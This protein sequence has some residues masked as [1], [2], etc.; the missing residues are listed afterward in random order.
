[1][2]N[3][4]TLREYLKLAMADLQQTRHRLRELETDATEPIAIVGMSCRFA[5]GVRTPEDL[6][7]LLAEGGDAVGGFPAD[8]GWDLESLYDPDPDRPGTS[9]TREGGFLTG[10]GDFDAG[11]FGISPREALAMDPQQRLLLETSWEVLERGGIDPLSLKGTQ[12]GVFIGTNGQDYAG[13][14]VASEEPVGGFVSTGNAASVVSGRISY[15]FGLE[16]PAVTVDTACSASLVALHLAVRSLR[17]RECS[18]AIAGGI[19]IMSTPGAFV[20]FSRQRGLAE[21]GR[22]KAF[23]AAADGTGW[24]E[25]VGMLLLMRLSDAQRLGHEVLA[26]VR[27]SAVNQDGASNGL[28]AP[29]GLS[30]QRVILRALADAHLTTADVDAVEAH[31]TGTTLGDPI[32][33]QALLATYGQDRTEPLK[34]GSVKSNLGHTQ[35]AAGVAGVIKMVLALRHDLLPKTLH[36]DAPTPHVDWTTGAVELLA[37]AQPWPKGDRPRRAGISSF[38]VSGTNAHT[39]IEEAPAPEAASGQPEKPGGPRPTTPWVISGKTAGALQAQAGRLRDVTAAPEDVAFSLLTT[40]ATL[41]H[42]AVVFDSAALS[43]LAEGEPAPGLVKGLA[44][45]TADR[46]AFVFPGQGS[47]WVGMAAELMDTSPV[48]AARMEECAAA[49]RPHVGWDLVEVARGGELER[50]DVVQPVLWAVMVS[51]AEVWRHHGVEPSAVVGHSQGEIAAACVAGALSVEDAAAVVALRSR[52]IL[53]LAGRGGMMSVALP[54]AEL[55][56]DDRLSI[57]AINGPSSVV[58]SGDVDAIEELRASTT[59]RTRVIPVDY[60]S[61]SHHVEEIHDELVRL[62]ADIAPRSSEVPFFSTVTATWLDTTTMDA[63][64]WYRN[65]RNTVRLEEVTRALADQGFGTFVEVSPHPGL[66]SAIQDTADNATVVGTLRRGEGGP[67]RFLTSLAEVHVAGTTVDWKITGTRVALPTYPFQQER[68]W[69][70]PPAGTGDVTA[71]GL[72]APGHPL[73]GAAAPLADSGGFLFT[74]RI[75]LR[76]HPWL[77]DHAV[78]GTVLLPGTAFVEM[79][80]RAGDETG[81]ALVEDL[82]LEAPL[83][84]TGQESVTVQVAVTSGRSITIHSRRGDD[85]PWTRHATGTLAPAASAGEG[86]ETWPVGE[87]V[88]LEGFYEAL[89][90]TGFAYGPAFQGLKRAWRDGADLYAEIALPPAPGFGIHPALLDAALHTGFLRQDG[91]PGL[92]FAWSDVALHATGAT[93]LRV[94]LTPTGPSTVTLTIA[95]PTG[96][97]V[98]TIGALTSRAPEK[99][100]THHDAFYTLTWQPVTPTTEAPDHTVV[101]FAPEPAGDLARAARQATARALEHLQADTE[102]V[103][104]FVTSGAVGVGEEDVHDL[105]NSPIWGLVRSAQSETPG[106]F[107][108]VDTD[109][110]TLIAEAVATGEPQVVVRDG[111]FLAPRLARAP[112]PETAPEFSGTVLV[113]GGT[114]TLGG[115]VARH[116]V[117]AHGVTSLVLVSRTGQAPDLLAELTA[118]GAEAV[119]EAC[120]VTDRA[121]LAEVF[122]RHDIGAVVHTAGALDDGVVASLTPERLDA[123]FAPKVD[124]VVHLHEL[125]DAPLIL[126]SAAAGI[127]GGPGQGNY[128]A[129]NA[130]TDALAR[131]RR[132]HGKPA[133]ALA[134]GFWAERSGLTGHLDD[135][136]VGRMGRSGVA[137][138]SS[139]EGLALFDA[140]VASGEPLIVP[141]RLDL[142]AVRRSGQVPPLLRGLVRAPARRVAESAGAESF[143]DRLAAA[144]DRERYLLDLVAA[145]VATVLGYATPEALD[146]TRAFKELGF[147]SLTAVDLRNRLGAA[148]GLKLPATLVFDYPNPEALAAHLSS[149]FSGTTATVRKRTAVADEP[150]AIVG[151]GCRYPGG[152]R[153]PEDLWRLVSEGVDAVSAFPA[154]RGWDLEALYDPDPDHPGTSYAREGGFLDGVADFDA[155]FFGIS[156]R[157]ALAMDPQQRLLLETSWEAFERAGIRPE[158]VRGS[159]TGVFAGVMYHD[160]ASHLIAG[161][162]DLTELEGYLGNGSAGSVASGRVAYS[163]G[164]EGPAVTVDTACSSSLVALHLAAQALRNGECDL[165]LAGGVTVLATPGLFTEFSKQRGLAADG[166]SKAFAAAADGAGFAEGAGMLLLE[167][168]SDARRHGHPILALIKGSAVNQDGASNGLTAPNGP[169][170]QRVIRQALA[171]AGLTPQDVDAIEAHGTGT[172][173]GDPIEA[174]ALLAT[175]GQDRDEP[176]R[177]GSIKSNIGHTQAAA[178][179]AGVIKMTMA[180]RHGL[181]PKTLH[182]DAPSPHVDWTEGAVELLTEPLP[183]PAGT[184]PRRAAISSF[185]VSGTN[186]HTI[187]EEAPAPKPSRA[188][189][190][191]PRGAGGPELHQAS[192]AS[193]GSAIDPVRPAVWPVSAKSGPAVDA[194]LARL[195]EAVDATTSPHDIAASLIETRSVFDHRAVLVGATTTDL[196]AATP[197]KGNVV[198]GGDRVVM[199]FPGQGSQWIGMAAE[200]MDT[201]PVFAARLNECAAALRP[202]VDWDLIETAR[203]GE[204]DRVDVVQ[205]VLWAV[206]VSLAELWRSYGVEP[207]AVIGHSQGEIAAACVA[208]AL[209]ID[210][211]AAVVALRSKAILALA[212][213]GGMMS[214]AL[215]AAELDL[216]DRLSIAAINGPSSVVVSGDVDAIEE[217]RANTEAR[218]RVIPVDYASHSH[219]VEEIH[220]DLIRLLAEISPQ[221]SHV[222]F[223]STVTGDWL[224]TTTMTGDYWYRNLR[225]T[226]RLEEATRALV[227]QG[228]GS[229]V[230]V[231][232]HPG[233]TFGI[234]ETLDAMESSAAVA[235]TLRRGEGGLDRFLASVAEAH[236]KGARVDWK[237]TGNRV[238]LPTYAF[239]GQRFWPA[240]AEPAPATAGDTA[241]WLAVDDGSL[242]LGVSQEALDEVLPAL[243]AW[244]R[245]RDELAVLDG[246]RYTITWKPVQ[247]SGAPTGRWQVPE[248]LPLDLPTEGDLEGVILHNPSLEELLAAVK[249]PEAKTWVVTS[250]AVSTGKADRVDHPERAQL[251]GLGGVAALELPESWGGLIDVPEELDDRAAAR[252]VAVLAGDEDQVAIRAGGVFARRLVHAPKPASTGSWTPRGTVLITGGTGALGAHAARWL[253]RN[254]AEHLILVSRRG[255]D[256]PGAAEL[257]EELSATVVACDLSDRRAVEQL[258]AE[259][260][261]DAVVHTAGV[262]QRTSL[263]DTTPEEL[264][265]VVAAK[266]DGAR[267]LHELLPNLDAFILYSSNSGVWGGGGQG[268]YAAANA[269]LDA[270]AHHRR[271]SGAKATSVAWGAWAGDG[272]ASGDAGDHLRRRGL[273]PMDPALAIAALQQVMDADDT[274]MAVADVD[275]D[276]FV[277]GYVAERARPLIADLTEARRILDEETGPAE[278][279]SGL[280]RRLAALT[281]TERRRALLTLVREQAAG[282]L[283]HA[284]ATTVDARRAFREIGFD[285]LTAV[286]LRDRLKT[287]TGLRLPASLVFDHPNPAALAD[288]LER[289]LVGV[290]A[291]T[292]QAQAASTSDEPI[293]IVAMACRYPG[294]VRTPEDLWKLL[295]DGTDAI[296]AFPADRGWNVDALYDADPD[297]SGTTYTKKGGFLHDAGGF[298]PGFFGISPREALAMDPQQR[299]LLEASWEVVERAGIDP[300]TLRGTPAGVFVG[301]STQG[302]GTGLE[303]A[304]EGA[305][306]YFLTGSATAVVSGR[307][308]YTLGLEG[309]AIT[310]D[311]ACSSSLVALHLAVQSL[312]NGEC[313]LALAGG[314]T[315][316]ATPGAFIEFS[317]QRGLAADGRCKAFSADADGTGWGEGVGLLLLERLS[318]AKANGHRVLAVVRGS[319]VNQDG[320]S[321]GLSAPNGPSQQRVIRQALAN[322]GLT[323]KDV[324]VVEAHGTG[325]RLGDPIEAQALL[326]TYGQDRDTPLYLGSV[327]S[328]IGHTQSASG[329]AGVIKMVLSLDHDVIPRTLHAAEPTP[330]VDWTAGSVELLADPT[331]WPS[332]DRPRRAAVSSFGVSGT[333]AHVVIEQAPAAVAR[334]EDPAAF[335]PWLLS[336]RTA[337]ALKA[338]VVRLREHIGATTPLTGLAHTLATTRTVF[339]HRAAITGSTRDDLLTGLDAILAGHHPLQGVV[340]SDPATVFLFTGQGSQRAGMGSGLYSRYPVFADAFDAV[341]AR[342]D[343][344]R[345]LHDVI[346]TGEGLD[347]TAYAQPAIF[348]LEVALFRL[349]ESWGVTP[350]AVAGHS[351]GELA[352]A[353]C[354]GILSL[355]DACALVT[356]RAS[357]MAALPSGGAMVALQVPPGE[358]SPDV[359]IA[360]INGPTSVVISGPEDAV[361][362]EA[363]RFPTSKRL[364]VSHA[365]H[366][367]L[368]DPMLD[369]FRRAIAGLTFNEP[370]IPFEGGRDADYWVRHVRD[371]VRFHDTLTRHAGAVFVEIGP[372]AALT[373]MADAPVIPTLTRSVPETEALITALAT[374]HVRGVAVDWAQVIPS[375]ADVDAPTYPFQ[376]E[377]Y[378]MKAAPGTAAG[379]AGLGIG[380]AGHPL[381]GAAVPLAGGDGFVYTGRLALATHPWLAD[382][383]VM[384]VVLLPGTAFVELALTAG[385]PAGCD[386]LEE[387]TLE[388]PLILPDQGGVQLQIV[389]GEPDAVGHRP[390]TIHSRPEGDEPW[391]RH[392][393]GR[394]SVATAVPAEFEVWPPAGAVSAPVDDLYDR[395]AE[396]GFPYGPAFQGVV[397]AWTRDD[398]VFAEVSLPSAESGFGLHP[399]VLDAALHSGRLAPGA[400][401]DEPGLPFS[402][403]GVEL[404]AS[405]ATEVRVRLTGSGTISLDLT[406]LT[407][408]PVATVEGFTSRPV[409]GERLR[410]AG[411]RN[412]SLFQVDWTPITVTPASPGHW[413]TLGDIGLELPIWNLTPNELSGI[414]PGLGSNALVDAVSDMVPGGLSD[415]MSDEVPGGTSGAVPDVVF[416]PIVPSGDVVS[417][418]HRA[419]IEALD[420]AQ[421]WVGDTRYVSSRLVV[422]TR[423]AVHD[424]NPDPAGAAVWGLIRSAQAEHPGRFVL[425][426]V[427]GT[428]TGAPPPSASSAEGALF[429]GES[430]IGAVS[431]GGVFGGPLAD[432]V[433]SALA[434]VVAS[435]EAQAAIRGGAVFVPRLARMVVEEVQP[436]DFSGPVLVTGATGTLGG[437][438]ARYLVTAHGAGELVLL[439]RRG[440]D[441]PGAAELVAEL[442]GLGARVS[443]KA[444][445]AADRDALAAALDGVAIGAVVHVAGVVDDG[446]VE[447]L[448]PERLATVMRPKVDAAWNLHELAGDGAFVLFSSASGIFG[449]P[450]QGNYAAANSFLDALAQHR[451]SIGRHATSLAW[452]M[453]ADRSAMTGDLLQADLIRI[454]R[455]GVGALS[456][457]EGLALFDTAVASGHAAAAPM[458]LDLTS[459]HAQARAGA[460]PPLLRGLVRA[461]A[462]P[463]AAPAAPELPAR[464]AG[465]DPDGRARVLLDLV[466]THVAGVLGH[467]SGAAVDPER[468][469]TELGFDSLTAV[470]LRNRINAVTGLALPATTVFDYPTPDALARHLDA[471]LPRDGETAPPAHAELDR[472]DTLLDGLRPDDRE[473][474]Y[475]T[476]R[477]R[478]LLAKLS[479]PR[480]AAELDTA[481]ADELFDLLDNELGVS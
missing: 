221:N 240:P 46:V 395:L 204:L 299:I 287:A 155:S 140:G 208:G 398:E 369:D 137:P 131:H 480:S 184:R 11:L 21:D 259:H 438:V 422:V 213:R 288:H 387:L 147:D 308:A 403:T 121:Q 10:A 66:T 139:A 379:A 35:A 93:E 42:R 231:S 443:V 192:E 223:F 351:V 90:E 449:A 36:V 402:W 29:N 301:A 270:L 159:L 456:T 70:R 168:V 407:G 347:D 330:H 142:A 476:G 459:L 345:P 64:Y 51:L 250:G 468:G 178:G 198:P 418:T 323:T 262:G 415:R 134:W 12:T 212:G 202:H 186:A 427:G 78:D 275:W 471:G 286:E 328:N 358:I 68:F 227:D 322:A 96:A 99:A 458:R 433:L 166:R 153:S 247:V 436:V 413:T 69:P 339:E 34:L 281:G 143:A 172:T 260:A 39:I 150:V 258:V 58:V 238:D 148:T 294:G 47:Q 108:L 220:D 138:L 268:A 401:S 477:L 325:T 176:A 116:L 302:Y 79:A 432:G 346:A 324:D 38:G 321:N 196:L 316:M 235:G 430:A 195:R 405:G 226:V 311:T 410:A 25:G 117:T 453:W 88:Q 296:G 391:V 40:R 291:E 426:D 28:T 254:G 292:G 7:R 24:G 355:D 417:A 190:P 460:L 13:L 112:L 83:T 200:L 175:Y 350:D 393:S 265:E 245:S 300:A 445:D 234:Q 100:T 45:P 14:L 61:H 282:V 412:D 317:R 342:F 27:G 44:S 72:A 84:L 314:V 462:R 211:A 380:A 284:D 381:L 55:D 313:T 80:L 376:R 214:V 276:R 243:T 141:V 383:A 450:G 357:L 56:L 312:R 384:G 306:G 75:S 437:H 374:L 107:V 5:G 461:P 389:V 478:G 278:E 149:R 225:N 111:E 406:D 129:A 446:I 414:V 244:R 320:A 165:A 65:L 101:R 255:P 144:P 207:A 124:A 372:D 43:A 303:A 132:H 310:V 382:H 315:V 16:G 37:D 448:T 33:A 54:A 385:S 263:A 367:Q 161:G 368:M 162:D 206:M 219:H 397:A 293:A 95:D 341:C 444:A 18:A 41:E 373:A 252:L 216:G 356:A 336:A 363:A 182:V 199:V 110:E 98:A 2:A 392:A 366:S 185:G 469:F 127:L 197:I 201:A 167:R 157:E 479:D 8:R 375:G 146:T 236:V 164:L 130:F 9:Y 297:S 183:W 104:V 224:D 53:A 421:M 388:A 210:D 359:D 181:L 340:R 32:E 209:S 454:T 434:A 103:V 163:F 180:L 280:A 338:G 472:L 89:A 151:I 343:L 481:T 128:A 77:A 475:L 364:K 115:L 464:L 156:P 113:T 203:S 474:A 222:P 174:Q 145:Q 30:Q 19:T 457:E 86:L 257:A 246:W 447:S 349:L 353:H 242:D 233:L 239:Q 3:E 295:S 249:N 17:S 371:T 266:V 229:F 136:Q 409:N 152:V 91:A 217:L 232:P 429:V 57:A 160:Y 390:V 441:A 218:T 187:I 74:G 319:A 191:E 170:Q 71:A 326:A 386:R 277:P 332:S 361:L 269:Y 352:A 425:V 416:A 360:A 114:G 97:P 465:L 394:L 230:E 452:G 193:A 63:E 334:R 335:V 48:F 470:E 125:T 169:S 50:V 408:R 251:W 466:C 439:S 435:G 106:R 179:V 177:L 442:E 455:S 290:S 73:L 424:Q 15:A 451:R 467:S 85:D 419:V 59:A 348:A 237:I 428:G 22:C 271:A 305:E 362:A 261:I 52:A 102:G 307:V 440:I 4:E 318:D 126:F 67:A 283:G 31:G 20:E 154:D 118:L 289:E 26:V 228:Y 194:Q 298:D 241:F 423:G 87:P 267:H 279:V 344:D 81:C 396:S 133:T 205:P 431:D 399:A 135:A 264:R 92:P 272:L 215:P 23:A 123:V 304:P 49:L 94:R 119:I 1:M 329:V 256:A 333:N 109:D 188:P 404:H 377:T 327:K 420:L 331:P 253:A 354:A 82:T 400:E 171:G 6:W 337:E 120:D 365:F 122:E 158:T 473:R 463:A 173:L 76:T 309:P 411:A 285:S 378:W 248:T 105:A 189:K 273:R 60:A 62:L 274:F 370:V